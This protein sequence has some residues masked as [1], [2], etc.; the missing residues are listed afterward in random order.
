M[1]F[2]AATTLLCWLSSFVFFGCFLVFVIYPTY[3]SALFPFA[4]PFLRFLFVDDP[5]YSILHAILPSTLILLAIGVRVGTLSM[6]LV[7]AVAAFVAP[8]V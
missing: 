8:T 3:I 5:A 6:F 7:V 1:S 4:F 2:F